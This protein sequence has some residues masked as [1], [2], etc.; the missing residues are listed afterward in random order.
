MQISGRPSNSARFAIT[1]GVAT[2]L[3]ADPTAAPFQHPQLQRPNP[4]SEQRHTYDYVNTQLTHNKAYAHH[5]PNK[6]RDFVSRCKEEIFPDSNVNG[7]SN[8]T[9]PADSPS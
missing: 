1:D 3:P 6:V 7:I 8:G 9:C 5:L 4:V 2:A